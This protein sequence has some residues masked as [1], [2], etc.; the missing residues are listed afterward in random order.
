MYKCRGQIC[1]QARGNTPQRY[2]CTWLT[3]NDRYLHKPTLQHRMHTFLGFDTDLV[4]KVTPAAQEQN[5][6]YAMLCALY[7]ICRGKYIGNDMKEMFFFFFNEMMLRNRWPV[8]M[9]CADVLCRVHS[10]RKG[11]VLFLF[12]FCCAK[13]NICNTRIQHVLPWTVASDRHRP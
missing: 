12:S 9:L 8:E 4:D 11:N 1:I 2:K 6:C 5:V 13:H 7:C 3:Y 10:R